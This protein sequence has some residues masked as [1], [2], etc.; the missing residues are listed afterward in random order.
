[1]NAITQGNNIVE[2]DEGI[3]ISAAELIQKTKE[4]NKKER[5]LLKASSAEQKTKNVVIRPTQDDVNQVK[6]LVRTRED[7]LHM[8]VK[9]GNRL[10]VKKTGEKQNIPK[11]FI[12]ES[13]KEMLELIMLSAKMQEKLIAE[14]LETVLRRFPIYTQWLK[15]NVSGVGPVAAGWIIAEFNIHTATN[16]SKMWQFAGL[17]PGMVLGVK[18]MLKSQYVTSMGVNKSYIH[19]YERRGA[20][21]R[22]NA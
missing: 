2:E 15:P 13:D 3:L 21:T 9:I 4:L 12:R 14:N 19:Y 10:G 6:L 8:R 22:I 16:V 1:M 11:G 18:D 7:F 17:N 20:C 5:A